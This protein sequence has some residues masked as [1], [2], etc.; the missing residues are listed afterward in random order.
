MFAQQHPAF[1]D[2]ISN[3]SDRRRRI[4]QRP[5]SD[6]PLDEG[7]MLNLISKAK[8]EGGTYTSFLLGTCTRCAI[9]KFV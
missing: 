9:R 8:S 2:K 1:K 6:K 3:I 4:F 5:F 7:A